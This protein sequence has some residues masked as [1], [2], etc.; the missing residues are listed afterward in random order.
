LSELPAWISKLSPA[1]VIALGQPSPQEG[2]LYGDPLA[3][4]AQARIQEAFNRA[5]R[6]KDAA[7]IALV[8]RA[9]RAAHAG[10]KRLKEI[11]APGVSERRLQLE[12]EH[13]AL[14]AGA[15]GFPYDSLVGAGANSAI[16]HA[17]PTEK[18][19]KEGELVLV[20]A[21]A[22]IHEYGVDITRSYA[23]G[24]RFDARQKSVYDLVHAAQK[25]AI[26]LCRPGVEWL[27][28]H[29]KAAR[30]LADGLKDLGLLKGSVDALVESGAVSVFFPHG[31]GHMVG[32]R[33]RDVGPR[34]GA[35]LRTRSGVRVRVDLPLEEGFLMTVE[36]GLYFVG[37]MLDD[38]K[39]RDKHRDT[40]AWEKIDV[41]KDFGGIRIEDD[42]L[43]TS[44]E[45]RNLTIAVEKA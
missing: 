38:P 40:V 41:W 4:E 1:R 10:Y 25:A 16:L 6:I 45:P 5:R 21:G 29:E 7:E 32:L 11:L 18:I 13:A 36:P 26:A 9:A 30:V 42:I 35:P 15:D 20:D 23:V 33:V 8:E 2:S 39:L 17:V 43:V 24:G 3:V 27:D 12:Y 14:M 19:L 31:I 37:P 22:E 44:G 28:V 34:V